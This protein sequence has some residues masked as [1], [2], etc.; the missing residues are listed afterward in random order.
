D[1]ATVRVLDR[2]SR[3]PGVRLPL[4]E[5]HGVETIPVRVEGSEPVQ[6]TFDLG[7]GTEVL[8]SARLAERLHLLTDGRAVHE[9]RG[10][11][12]GGETARKR[13]VL[14]SVELGGQTLT[15]VPAAL[16]PN[17]SAS[18][19]NVGVAVLRHFLVTSDFAERSVWLQ[20]RRP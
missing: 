3:L 2:T 19:L 4:T 6:A 17:P 1:G 20:A 15:E 10:G 7:N 11:G 16:D 5:E 13:F 18:D 8:V 12:L 14:H 9:G